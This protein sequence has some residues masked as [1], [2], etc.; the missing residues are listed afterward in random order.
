MR[1]KKNI[2]RS[3]SFPPEII[4]YIDQESDRLNMTKSRFLQLL[5]IK[6]QTNP[7]ERIYEFQR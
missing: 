3:F 1:T 4:T 5:V 2:N 6:Y 7:E